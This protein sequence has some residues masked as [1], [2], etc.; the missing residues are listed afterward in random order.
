M[1]NQSINPVLKGLMYQLLWF[2]FFANAFA[3]FVRI[4]ARTVVDVSSGIFLGILVIHYLYEWMRSLKTK[5][6]KMISLLML[7]LILM[8]VISAIQAARVFGQ[9]AIY[10]FLAQRQVFMALCA[11]FI[12]TALER[13]WLS[14][15]SFEKYFVRS[16]QILLFIFLI[17][18]MFVNPS[19]FID[20]DFVTFSPNKGVR[21]EFPDSCIYGLFLY[22]LFKVWIKK[23]KKWWVT[24]AFSL[25]YI[26]VY[27][28]D[29]TQLV[30]LA[31][32]VGLYVLLNFSISRMIRMVILGA[33][34]ILLVF[35]LLAFM[36]P[37]FL[38]KN[39][40]LY[41]TAFETLTGEK[42]AE[43][44]T[45]IR[46]LESKIALAGFT[47]HQAIGVGFLST[48]W[49]DG[50][51]MINKYFYP[52]DV[53]LLGNLYVYGIIGTLV[54]YI[55]FLFALKYHF[56]LRKEHATLLVAS[57][58]VLIFLFADM[59]T[60]ATNQKFYGVIAVFFG[61]VY[62][63]RFRNNKEEDFELQ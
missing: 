53:G 59:L 2:L 51:R 56:K 11:H 49:N 46:F 47:D 18:Y 12:V 42:V 16:L 17:F 29:R 7:P 37:D 34:G 20:T 33:F 45:N 62:Y 25:F 10:G 1:I 8:P 5:K 63:Y 57:Q 35:G 30:A 6:V 32:T 4:P 13:K 14:E 26:L 23:E 21:Y 41:A 43:S 50:F 44:S 27:L 54:F 52:T 31:G 58:Y 3:C 48:R 28:L 9:P 55:P 15:D 40:K 60:A 38:D 24:V 22:S 39:L 36:A 19:R 61:I